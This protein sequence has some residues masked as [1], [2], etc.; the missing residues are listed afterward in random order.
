MEAKDN[1]R[2]IVRISNT[3]LDGNRKVIDSIRK[4]KG[5]S[6]SFANAVLTVS[7]VDRHKKTGYLVE[8]EVRKID[9]AIATSSKKFPVWM[10]NRRRGLETN[11]SIHLVTSDLTYAQENDIRFM[12][13]IKTYKGI[14]HSEGAPARGQRTRSNFRKNKG[15]V[16]GVV[17]SKANAPAAK[18]AEG[19]SEKPAKGGKK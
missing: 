14:R 10:L 8:E 12:R 1:F 5:V 15:K 17:K 3:D 6:F 18:P 19:K 16:L 11:E 13:R 7:G 4:I 9:E 2:H